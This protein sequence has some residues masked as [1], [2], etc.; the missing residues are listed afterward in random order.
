MESA[1]LCEMWSAHEALRF[2]L[3]NEIVPVLR[4]GGRFIPNPMVI[5]DR[6]LDE[7]G[8]IVHGAKKSGDERTAARA[9]RERAE[10]DFTLLDE[11]VARLGGRLL[12]TVPGCLMKTVDGIRKHKIE[13]WDRNKHTN[14]SWLALNMTTEGR[15]GFQA[16]NE[17]PRGQREVD[18]AELRRLQADGHPWNDELRRAISPQYTASA[19]G[20]KGAAE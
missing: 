4:D 7:Y 14:R 20:S 15:A 1:T 10:I 5:T 16:F 19:V 17:G 18:F 12:A 8:R 2:G 3:I 11:A 13:G 6:W 9:V